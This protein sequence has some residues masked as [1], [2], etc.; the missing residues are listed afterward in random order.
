MTDAST[1]QLKAGASSAD[2][3]QKTSSKLRK[4]D[5][6]KKRWLLDPQTAVAEMKIL[7][8]VE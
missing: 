4:R 6:S 8:K 1:Y 5:H 7:K 3:W 2:I